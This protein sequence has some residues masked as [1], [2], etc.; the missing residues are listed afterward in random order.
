MASASS[1]VDKR[2]RTAEDRYWL[3]TDSAADFDDLAYE[4]T[5]TVRSTYVTDW[6][7]DVLGAMIQRGVVTWD[8]ADAAT[9]SWLSRTLSGELGAQARVPA[10][11]SVRF[12]GS[13]S[14]APAADGRAPVVASVSSVDPRQ[15]YNGR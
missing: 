4:F 7:P 15:S 14:A 9:R 8:D 11:V 6:P 13:E 5:A 3:R 12:T 1:R 10:L 2:G